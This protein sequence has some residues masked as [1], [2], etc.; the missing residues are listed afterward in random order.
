MRAETTAAETASVLST[1]ARAEVPSALK[2]DTPLPVWRVAQCKTAARGFSPPRA[3]RLPV[4]LRRADGV[5]LSRSETE[6]GECPC[7]GSQS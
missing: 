5:R 6:K 2:T 4:A 7:R 3:L 1:C